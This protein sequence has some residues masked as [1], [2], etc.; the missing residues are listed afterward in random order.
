MSERAVVEAEPSGSGL[1]TRPLLSRAESAKQLADLKVKLELQQEEAEQASEKAITGISQGSSGEQESRAGASSAEEIWFCSICM[2]GITLQNRCLNICGEQCQ[3]CISCMEGYLRH[4]VCNNRLPVRCPCAALHRP[5]SP[6]ALPPQGMPE[7]LRH[8]TGDEDLVNKYERFRVAR[9]DPAVRECPQCGHLQAGS[10]EKP[11]ITCDKCTTQFCFLCS[12]SHPGKDCRTSKQATLTKM[13]T[14]AWERLHA[15]KCPKC[16]L[17]VQR[18]KGCSHMTCRC[19][20]EFCYHCGKELKSGSIFHHMRV[21]PGYRG[22]LQHGMCHSPSMW[23]QRVGAMTLAVPAIAVGM[24]YYTGKGMYKS[25]KAAPK[26]A[27]WLISGSHEGPHES[28]QLRHALRRFTSTE[29]ESMAQA[30]GIVELSRALRVNT[31]D[32]VRHIMPLQEA[33]VNVATNNSSSTPD[34]VTAIGSDEPT[35]SV[36]DDDGDQGMQ[37]VTIRTSESLSLSI[38][39]SSL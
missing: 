11:N 38:M 26:M 21:F 8:V 15:T 35:I 28:R 7:L 3:V 5:G 31:L 32:L 13:Q 23:A 20:C 14:W 4:E 6:Q 9:A 39:E 34:V 29:L 17:P 12:C 30:V 36:I 33:R 19:G 16:R 37:I 24:L 1:S 25:G 18:N 27:R 2:S 22:V 10:K